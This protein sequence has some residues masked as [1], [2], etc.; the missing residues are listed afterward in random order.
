MAC[1]IRYALQLAVD[2]ILQVREQ[3]IS[4]ESYKQAQNIKRTRCNTALMQEAFP[5]LR[6]KCQ[7]V[8]HDVSIL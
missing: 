6:S 3:K 2:A 8:K 7:S 1:H 4:S 5:K